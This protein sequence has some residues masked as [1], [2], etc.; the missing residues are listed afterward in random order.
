MR[1]QHDQLAASC[2]SCALVEVRDMLR[3]LRPALA[4]VRRHPMVRRWLGLR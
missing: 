2:E 3:E 4:Q 1:C